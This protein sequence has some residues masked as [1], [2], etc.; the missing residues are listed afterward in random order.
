MCPAV[1][2]ACHLPQPDVRQSHAPSCVAQAVLPRQLLRA[3][4]PA[5]LSSLP[6]LPPRNS[7]S[8]CARMCAPRPPTMRIDALLQW[9]LYVLCGQR[10]VRRDARGY[11]SCRYLYWMALIAKMAVGMLKKGSVG[12]VTARCLVDDS[13]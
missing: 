2:Q 13:L 6:P 7:P 8:A 11:C 9:V 12:Q 4:L 1:T 10:A 3:L 5:L